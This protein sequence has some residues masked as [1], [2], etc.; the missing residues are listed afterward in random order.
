[1]ALVGS[2]SSLLTLTVFAAVGGSLIAIRRR[3]ASAAPGFRVPWTLAGVPVPAV[4]LLLAA[5]LLASQ[6]AAP[7]YAVGAGVLAAGLVLH[8]LWRRG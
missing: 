7:V 4:L 6:F 1:V 3:A 5:P 2:V 8:A